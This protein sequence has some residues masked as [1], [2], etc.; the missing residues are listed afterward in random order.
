MAQDDVV[1]GKTFRVRTEMGYF[2]LTINTDK[3]GLPT[4]VMSRIGKS[5]T[6]LRGLLE[7]YSI[8]WSMFLKSNKPE[9][10]IRRIK[11]H[12]VGSSDDAPIVSLGETYRSITDFIARKVLEGF[13]TNAEKK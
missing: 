2:Y 11:K 1:V 3:N 8:L 6:L 9:E 5:G 4:Q 10:A 12:F 7:N 13:E